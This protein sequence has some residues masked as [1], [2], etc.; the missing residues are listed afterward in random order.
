ME[1]LTN[2]PKII[3]GGFAIDER[4][5][6]TFCN[7][8][9]FKNVKRFY[10]LENFSTNTIRAFHGHLKEGKYMFVVS[11][12][13]L[14]CVV[15]LDDVKKPR[16]ENEVHRFVLSA[17]NPSILYIPKGFANGLRFLE[18]NTKMIVFSTSSLE[19]SKKDDYRFPY[20]YWGKD[21]W[22]I[23]NY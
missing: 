12:T 23:K 1:N 17:I 22:E 5:Q 11:G 20:D 15:Q 19:E 18:K 3:K 10:M 13:A 8:F 14:V 16:K 4:G 6:V 7:D 9:D 21:I 2:K